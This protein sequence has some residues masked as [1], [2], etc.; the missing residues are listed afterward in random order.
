[1]RMKIFLV[2]VVCVIFTAACTP[3]DSPVEEGE[4][5]LSPETPVTVARGQIPG[6]LSDHNPDIIAVQGVPFA[7]PPVGNLRWKPPEPVSS[8]TGIRDASSPGPMCPQVGRGNQPQSEDCLFLNVWTP[9]KTSE[10][11]PVMV[12]IHGGGYRLGAGSGTDGAPLA[13]RGVV[14]VSINYRL[15]VFGFLA[16]PALSAESE[17]NASGNY[18]LMDM[19]SA[20]GWVQDN[21]A[22]FG[23]DPDRVTIFGESAGGGSVMSLMVVPQA[24]GLFHRAIAQSTY[25]PGW[26]RG[27]TDAPP[28][29]EPA[30]DQGQWIAENLNATGA[31][32]SEAMRSAST[33]QIMEA[34]RVGSGSVFTRTPPIWAPNIDGWYIPDDPLLMH[35]SGKQHDVP[36]IAGMTGNEGSLFRNR[37]EINDVAA[38]KSHIETH[39]ASVGDQALDFYDVSSSDELN[40][41]I[42]HLIHD[43]I[44]AGPVRSQVSNHSQKTNKAWLYSFSRIPPTE[45]GT[46][47]GAHH[48][49]E[50]PYVFGTMSPPTPWTDIDRHVSNTIMSY[51]TQFA[52]SGDPNSPGLP[53]WP[54]FESKTDQFLTL[55]AAIAV[56]TGLHRDGAE[57]FSQFEASQRKEN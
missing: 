40:A 46:N 26:A 41:G 39:Y 49:A 32:A 36:L 25:V 16:H 56:G 34:A 33:E 29:W 11:L 45:G 7:A 4:F 15:N 43:M 18:G 38:F 14:L 5:T 31:A 57:L 2:P 17:H 10:P 51:W 6:V 52:A 24:T 44:F 23:G 8:W 50:L 54:P 20:L 1:M 55:D 13:S 53:E 27:L 3:S 19:V 21:I 42:D 30:E 28:G 37:L 48:A 47:W 22:S 9:V 35:D 12:W